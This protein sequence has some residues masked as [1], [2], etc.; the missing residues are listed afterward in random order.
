LLIVYNPNISHEIAGHIAEK[1]SKMRPSDVKFG[2]T[3][4]TK[5]NDGGKCPDF[6]MYSDDDPNSAKRF[7]GV[8]GKEETVVYPTVV[9]EVVYSESQRNLAEDCARWISCSLGRVHLAIGIDINYT[10][11]KDA[12]GETVVG[13]RK[14]TSIHG[15]TWDMEK[16][17]HVSEPMSPEVIDVLKR[18]DDSQR[19]PSSKYYCLSY[20]EDDLYRFQLCNCHKFQ[21]CASS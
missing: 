3:A 11:E 5:L 6:C 1:L 15:Y 17:D 9:M 12:N 19:G 20:L 8:D 4:Y 13:S 18:A 21:V 2:G 10:F 14:L 7:R 16:I